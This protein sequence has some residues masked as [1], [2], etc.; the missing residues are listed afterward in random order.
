MYLNRNVLKTAIKN[1]VSAEGILFEFKVE[2]KS[3]S[4][5]IQ[6]RNQRP[7]PHRTALHRTADEATATPDE[8]T[9]LHRPT[10]PRAAP[11]DE[12]THRTAPHRTAHFP[13]M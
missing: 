7:Q 11:L 4:R 6:G 13:P 12:A 10:K 5:S 3:E 8:A 1:N 2:S 9:A